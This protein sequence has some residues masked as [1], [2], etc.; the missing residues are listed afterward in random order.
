MNHIGSPTLASIE[1]K[2]NRSFGKEPSNQGNNRSLVIA[3]GKPDLP[4]IG[5]NLMDE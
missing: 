5:L 1:G 4:T 3:M 2:L